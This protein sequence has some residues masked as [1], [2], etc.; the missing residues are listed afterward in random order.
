MELLDG[1]W[2]GRRGKGKRGRFD[3]RIIIVYADMLWFS[4]PGEEPVDVWHAAYP[5]TCLLASE[6]H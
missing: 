3:I 2:T 4:F 6:S 5:F 1:N